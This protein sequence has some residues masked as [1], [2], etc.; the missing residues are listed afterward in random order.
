MP[1]TTFY[2]VR[3]GDNDVLRHA[4]AGRRPGV[5]LNAR[6]RL[7][8]ERLADALATHSIQ[9]ICSSPLE[10]AR[11]T[12]E[13]LAKRLNLPI[14]FSDELL[15]VDFADWT[16]K[17]MAD[18]DQLDAWKQWTNFRTGARVPGGES[19]IEV[20]ARM[21]REIERL[22]HAHPGQTV[23]L[24][25]HGDP[26]RTALIYYLGMPLDFIQRLA[27]RTA[28]VSILSVDDQTARLHAFNLTFTPDLP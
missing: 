8:A 7:Q 20:Q 2:L 1:E 15:E 9:Q 13:P 16:G 11:Q 23:A 10:R 17:S 27:I 25:S 3:H 21:V 24:F 12:A 6:G 22:C 18:L 14:Q 19:I 5:N 4:I 26:I 28:S